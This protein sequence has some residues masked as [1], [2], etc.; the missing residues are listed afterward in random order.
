MEERTT[1]ISKRA[2]ADFIGTFCLV[3]GGCGSAVLA[4]AF[5]EL[6]IGFLGDALA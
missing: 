3:L 2:A 1:P 4:V 5:P 6:G